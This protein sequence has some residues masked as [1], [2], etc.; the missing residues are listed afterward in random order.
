ML[1]LFK[2]EELKLLW[3]FYLY[4]F[5]YGLSAMILPFMIIYFRNLNFSFFQISVITSAFAISMF[6]FEV[7]TGAFADGLSRKYSVVLGFLITALA[8]TLIPL[9]TNFYFLII[10]W[11]LAGLGMTFVSGAEEAWVIDNLNKY[12]RK[13][14]HH[15]F[16]VKSQI[17]ASFGIIFAPLIGAVLVKVHSIKILWF[18]FGLGFLLNALILLFFGKE[19]YKPKKIRF[20]E[21]F[22]KTYENSKV[23]LKFSRTHKT[24]FL[25]ILG[26]IF[27][28]LMIVGDNGWQPLMLDLSMPTY[29]LGLMY[30]I[31]A[32]VMIA[33]SL[34]S[35]LFVN[36]KVK[37]VISITIFT[38]MLLLL[39]L[40]LINPPFYITA[41]VIFILIHS[42]SGLNQPL[43]QT[44]FH[45]FVPQNI[46]ATV[47][48]VQSMTKQLVI[49]LAAL[50]AGGLLDIFGPKKVLAYGGLFGI[51]AIISYLKIKD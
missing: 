28:S 31:L 34:S 13:D 9:F 6:L 23:G 20:I 33:F 12:K 17:V 22:K 14:L 15:E 4:Y 25:L 3:P 40:L 29:T 35:R 26:S 8:A 48:S 37:T 43:L 36:M 51:F 46:R 18:V 1:M 50:I 21:S 27:A 7:P 41:A 32:V 45:K 39:S 44:Y 49:A 11:V 42:S 38:Q 5:I 10:L 30:S 16:F 19:L 47:V 2:K 24:I